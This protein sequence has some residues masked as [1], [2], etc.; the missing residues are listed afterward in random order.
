[1]AKLVC[2]VCPR[3]CALDITE[4]RDGFHVTG[5]T[6]KRGEQFAL[7]EMTRPMRT[8]CSTVRTTLPGVPVVPVRVSGEIPKDRIFDVM[9]QIKGACLHQAVPRG[10][11]VIRDV[12]GLNVD[13]ITTSDLETHEK[14]ETCHE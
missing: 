3:G 4:A 7:S 14:G 2:I 1:M 12:L 13:V 5:N 10:T 11:V 6:C 9:A 8:I